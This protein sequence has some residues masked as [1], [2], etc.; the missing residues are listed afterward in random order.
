MQFTITKEENQTLC[1]YL[2]ADLVATCG[3]KFNFEEIPIVEIT[4]IT[5]DM[6]DGQV[7]RIQFVRETADGQR[8]TE[9]TTLEMDEL[10]EVLHGG[11]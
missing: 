5:Y 7:P 8:W 4:S 2:E 10:E 1:K 3:N 9:Y 11:M 6:F